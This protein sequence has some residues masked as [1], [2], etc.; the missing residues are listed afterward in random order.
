MGAQNGLIIFPGHHRRWHFDRGHLFIGP[1][2]LRCPH[3]R[4]L[5]DERIK[6]IRGRRHRGI[7]GRHPL[8]IGPKDRIR[9]NRGINPIGGDIGGLGKE[10]IQTFGMAH[11]DIQPD[12]AAIGPAHQINLVDLNKIQ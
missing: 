7:I 4:D 10:M 1:V 9:R 8:D 5:G 6:L 11:R 3:F 12:D 2:R